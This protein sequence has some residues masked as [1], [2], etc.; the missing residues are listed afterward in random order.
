ME[1]K[2][3]YFKERFHYFCYVSTIFCKNNESQWG[4]NIIAQNMNTF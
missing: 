3:R 2:R 1:H 4:P